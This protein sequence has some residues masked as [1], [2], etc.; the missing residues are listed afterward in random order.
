EGACEIALE[1]RLELDQQRELVV[2]AQPLLGQ[3][4]PDGQALTQWNAHPLAH[5]ERTKPQRRSERSARTPSTAMRGSA[6]RRP[7][8]STTTRIT[9]SG[10]PPAA[11]AS[12]R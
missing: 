5:S 10:L 2:L 12:P 11:S 8:L 1:E 4:A 7:A 6:S 9:A 3:I